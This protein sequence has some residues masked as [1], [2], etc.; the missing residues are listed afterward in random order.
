MFPGVGDHYL[1]MAQELYEKEPT[2]YNAIEQCCPTLHPYLGVR[3]CDLLY[4]PDEPSAP[5][6]KN[7]VNLRAMLGRDEQEASPTAKK[8]KATAVA[9]PVVF[10]VEYALA[11]LLMSWGLQPQ[12][13]AGYSLGEYVAACLAGVL[14]L[15]DALK[16]V[17]ERAQ[18]IQSL[19]PGNMLTVS[20]SK[21][22]IQPFLADDV[23]LAIHCGETACVLAGPQ[24]AIARLEAQ[25]TERNVAS[26]LLDT[27]HAL[28]S[29]MMIP[30]AQPLTRLVQTLTL[31]PPQIPYISDVTGTWITPEQATDPAYWAQHMCQPVRF[32]DALGELLSDKN[33]I[34]LE[35]GPG[36]SLGAFAKQHPACAPEQIQLVLPTMRYAYDVQSDVRFLLQ[37]L[38][39]LWLAGTEIAWAA[40]HAGE[41]RRRIPLPTYPFERQRFWIEPQAGPGT[42]SASAKNPNMAEWFYIPSWKRTLQP[43]RE[44]PHDAEKRCYLLFSAGDSVSTKLA[45]QLLARGDAVITVLAGE[46]FAANDAAFTIRL[47][48]QEDYESLLAA[49]A[50]RSQMPTHIVHLWNLAPLDENSADFTD[51]ALQRS[52]YSL[53]FLAQAQAIADLENDIHLVVISSNMQKVTG[54]ETVHPEKAA[55]L[56][57]CKVIPQEMPH[58][59]C[60]SIDIALPEPDSRQEAQLVDWLVAEVET[61]PADSIVA[62]RGNDRLVQTYEMIPLAAL[63]TGHNRK[64]RE[65]GVYLITGGLGGIGLALADYL[66]RSVRAKL[67]LTTRAPF[68]A[69][70]AWDGWLATHDPQDRT[71][72]RIQALRALQALDAEVL[73][74]QADVT[75]LRQME[76]VVRAALERWN[77]I[78]GVIHAAGL[79]GGGLIQL[80]TIETAAR[81]L[82]PKIHGTRILDTVLQDIPLDFMLLCSSIAVALGGPGQVDYC[83]ANAFLDAF[84][85]AHDQRNETMAVAIDWDM[86]GE[87]GLAVNT[88]S[89]YATARPEQA[90]QT[91][92]IQ[93]PLL[94]DR[95]LEATGQTVYRMQLNPAE[96]WVLSEHPIMG[97][98]TAPSTTFLE[99]AHAAFADQTHAT[100]LEIREIVFLAP[101]MVHQNDSK[102]AHLILEQHGEEFNFQVAS[103]SGVAADGKPQWQTHAIGRLGHIDDGL[104][105]QYDIETIRARCDALQLLTNEDMQSRLPVEFLQMGPRWHT[106]KRIHIGRDEALACLELD[107]AF[108]PDLQAF[109]LH[110]ALLDVAIG[111]LAGGMSGERYLPLAYQQMRVYSSLPGRFYSYVRRK[112]DSTTT[113]ETITVQVTLLDEHGHSIV[114]IEEF[115]MKRVGE[116]AAHPQDGADTQPQPAG[117]A[118]YR[119]DVS[120]ALA[121]EEGVEA[122]QRILARNYLPQIIVSTRH[123]PTLVQKANTLAQTLLSDEIARTETPGSK[124]PRPNMRTPYVPP[125]TQV[126]EELA[127]IW[128]NVLGVE[129]I[130]THD[131]F[132]D[133]GGHSLLATQVLSRV[134]NVFKVN[135]HIREMFE[136]STIAELAQRVETLQWA[137]RSLAVRTGMEEGHEEIEL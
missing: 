26:R 36:Q 69:P 62:Y 70:E 136:I 86:W 122:F 18:M 79:P 25:L 108:L 57:P 105:R 46:Q 21:E 40:F 34:L 16:L 87:V 9:Q 35:V 4:P 51:K 44:E 67:V 91:T 55:L 24:E 38:G 65:G 3:L 133:L 98:P 84:A 71:S 103:Q 80:K 110:P 131:S 100:Q 39:Q 75:E 132:F 113:G 37:T 60:R 1:Q 94:L 130:G 125:R 32:F 72:L 93:H 29:S 49:L 106:L 124:H 117:A 58:V 129:Q 23:S 47:A 107:E 56:G 90:L 128:S 53:L 54:D 50:E 28:H 14:S 96:H 83:A 33:R 78:H 7:G 95:Y 111:L 77:T 61:T 73:V 99:L 88:P 121:T 119:H 123:L 13:M 43:M 63:R 30:L 8:L 127:T 109:K 89:N 48:H 68:P 66:A 118:P 17:A 2:F 81:V 74:L 31:N 82:N 52:F 20:L 59:S 19:P 10:A 6:T 102:K 112:P 104:P 115:T 11:R 134:R 12:A 126:E 64:L 120:Q 76:A 22:A 15:E 97:I 85:N 101:L 45:R 41:Q 5:R 27:P 42:P 137:A 92:P 114:D 116:T 135:M